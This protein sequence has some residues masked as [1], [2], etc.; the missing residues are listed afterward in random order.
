[1]VFDT[2]RTTVAAA[3]IYG[4]AA[5]GLFWSPMPHH[6]VSKVLL[7]LVPF[8]LALFYLGLRHGE[9]RARGR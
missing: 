1:M 9:Y 5:A 3:L 4:L 2:L 6:A 7:S 8:G